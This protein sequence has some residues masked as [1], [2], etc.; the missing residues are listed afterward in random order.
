[1]KQALLYILESIVENKDTLHVDESEVDGVVTFTI[2]VAKEDM[3]KV[4]GKDGK[5]IRSIRNVMKI[6]AMKQSK[7]IQISLSEQAQ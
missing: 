3:G 5:V 7:K 6:P 1:M 4:I 2:T